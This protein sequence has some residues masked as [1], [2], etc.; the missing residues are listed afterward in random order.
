MISVG[1][2]VGGVNVKAGVLDG[3]SGACSTVKVEPLGTDSAARESL[4]YDV[5]RKG[6]YFDMMD[7]GR[8]EHLDYIVTTE[9]HYKVLACCIC[10]LCAQNYSL[11]VV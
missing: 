4:R 2:E 5:D 1:L 6:R 10:P 8:V 7:S 3:L 11:Q 9:Y